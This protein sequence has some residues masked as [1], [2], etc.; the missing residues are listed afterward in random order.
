MT[1]TTATGETGSGTGTAGPSTGTGKA[2]APAPAPAWLG[3]VALS[4][5]IPAHDDAHRISA[6]L[7]AFRAH[8]DAR[9]G[10]GP[11]DWELVVA[12]DASTDDTAALVEAAAA[13]EPRIR[14]I[15]SEHHRG[16]GAALRAAVLACSGERV[17]LADAGARTPPAE[18]D[19]LEQ[20]L[21]PQDPQNGSGSGSRSGNENE[22]ESP[23]AA[24]GRT[25][26]RLVRALGIPGIPGFRADTCGFALFDGDRAR[27]AF[28]AS[29]PSPSSTATG[30]E[31]PSAPPSSTARPSTPRSCGGCAA[32]AG[33]WPRYR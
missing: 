9:L 10:T 20:A 26:N 12:D 5:V 19:H 6:T 21:V 11:G 29:V 27:A 4:V 22:S 2:P 25:G 30:P 15:R 33:T 7:D 23:T 24:L 16:K 28:G 14:L 13:D 31:P 8:L 1:D 3:A 32:R 17:L 18:L